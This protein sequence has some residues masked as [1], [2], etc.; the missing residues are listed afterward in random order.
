M[1]PMGGKGLLT[2][3]FALPPTSTPPP[4]TTA[5]APVDQKV[6][7]RVD[8]GQKMIDINQYVAPLQREKKNTY[9]TNSSDVLTNFFHEF[10]PQR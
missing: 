3:H 9:L 5:K 2:E 4:F 8:D 10:F 7:S 1:V 6:E